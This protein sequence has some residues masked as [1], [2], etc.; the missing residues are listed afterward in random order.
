MDRTRAIDGDASVCLPVFQH[1]VDVFFV[2]MCNVIVHNVAWCLTRGPDQRCS[3]GP[4]R[5]VCF[6]GYS[7]L[8][9][10]CG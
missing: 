7:F 4:G 2:C 9:Q 1:Y 5:S 3:N 8:A 6:A 10:V